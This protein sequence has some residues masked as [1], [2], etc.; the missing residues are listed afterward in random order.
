M[1]PI[2]SLS[3]FQIH[4]RIVFPKKEHILI[5]EK[6]QQIISNFLYWHEIELMVV[7]LWGSGWL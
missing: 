3:Y 1:C 2:I 6:L 7:P 5:K 4:V